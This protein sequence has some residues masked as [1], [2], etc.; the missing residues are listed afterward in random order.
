MGDSDTAIE[1]APSAEVITTPRGNDRDRLQ[2]LQN[3]IFE[4]SVS[5]LR[6]LMHFDEWPAGD[7]EKQEAL[8]LSWV[9]NGMKPE[10]A[11]RRANLLNAAWM[12]KRDAPVA[13][14]I[15]RSVYVSEVKAR[16]LENSAPKQMN[17]QVVAL[18]APIPAFR[19]VRV[20]K[21]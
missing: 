10:E 15:L 2:A 14:D 4:D 18:S 16:S 19:R 21:E 3:E 1:L 7:S 17:V 20:D 12:S 5:K 9:M 6:M 8:K 11:D 13:L